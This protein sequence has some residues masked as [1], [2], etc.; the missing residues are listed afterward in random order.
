MIWLGIPGPFGWLGLGL[1]LIGLE[2]L[3]APGS[4]LLWIGLAALGM[5]AAGY[6]GA[7]SAGGE[8]ALF[9]VL[10]LLFGLVGWKV[11]G[12]RGGSDAAR[13]LHDPAVTLVGRVF[14]L[15]APIEGGIGQ[16]RIDDTVWRV[17]GAD[18]PEGARVKVLALDGSTL[19]VEKV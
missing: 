10:S 8:I 14:V 12:A 15:S 16:V 4:Y 9:G 7:M 19:V 5:A 6:A 18:M 3:I 1:V 2:V 13:A 11:Y 17:S